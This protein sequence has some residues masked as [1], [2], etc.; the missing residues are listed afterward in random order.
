[1]VD[2]KDRLSICLVSK[3]V[4]PKPVSVVKNSVGSRLTAAGYVGA[5]VVVDVALSGRSRTNAVISSW[6][7]FEP[8][9]VAVAIEYLNSSAQILFSGGKVVPWF[10]TFAINKQWKWI[11]CSRGH[12]ETWI[13]RQ[14]PLCKCID[15]LQLFMA[16]IK[17]GV[18]KFRFVFT[19]YKTIFGQ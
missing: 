9:F 7:G 8:T 15:T 11:P 3:K 1:M 2:L 5:A 4:L 19:F 13:A 18:M 16:V 17:D 10:S 14:N 6:K 12:F